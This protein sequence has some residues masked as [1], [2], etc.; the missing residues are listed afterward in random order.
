MFHCSHSV[1]VIDTVSKNV[2]PIGEDVGGYRTRLKKRE[3]AG[4]RE[5]KHWIALCGGLALRE[6]SY[7]S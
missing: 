3:D 1:Y 5:R 7:L 4:I 2:I 6:A